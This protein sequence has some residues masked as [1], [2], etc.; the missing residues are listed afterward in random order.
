MGR[1]SPFWFKK[2]LSQHAIKSSATS[3][4]ADSPLQFHLQTLER[5]PG[6]SHG[7]Y[8]PPANKDSRN[9]SASLQPNNMMSSTFTKAAIAALLL[10]VWRLY[11]Q[12]NEK[13]QVITGGLIFCQPSHRAKKKP[14]MWS[15][16][17][18]KN[19]SWLFTSTMALLNVCQS[20]NEQ[21][22]TQLNDI[23]ATVLVRNP[24]SWN[25][26]SMYMELAPAWQSTLL[27]HKNYL[28]M[29]WP[30]HEQCQNKPKKVSPRTH[31][32]AEH[33]DVVGNGEL[34]AVKLA[35]EV[36][37]YWLGCAEQ[38]FIIWTDKIYKIF[39]VLHVWQRL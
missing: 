17:S 5:Q 37:S 32:P 18:V 2:E 34:S 28:G 15:N 9:W 8:Y 21:S 22:C 12:G 26:C 11:Y 19:G 25:L 20:V 7:P 33:D 16:I 23:K 13:Q 30:W 31:T 24:S 27:H 35:L 14:V 39:N 38:P 4:D 3:P 36:W 29:A 6:W 10:R 1:T